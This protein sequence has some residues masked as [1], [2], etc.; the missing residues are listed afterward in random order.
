MRMIA[1]GQAWQDLG[2]DVR[3]VGQLAPLVSRIESEGFESIQI[4]A[5][6]PDPDDIHALL[7]NTYKYD[8]VAIDGYHFDAAY[9]RAVRKAGRKTLVLDDF[10][11][12]NEYEADLLLNQNPDAQGSQYNANEDISFLLGSKYALIRK[13][14][15][16][17][18]K[19]K[20]TEANRVNNVLVTM[21]DDD[22][23]NMTPKILDAIAEFV[24][25]TT[26][27]K[28]ISGAANPN[29]DELKSK[30]A[31]QPYLCDLLS[32]VNNI[33]EL[34]TWA[35]IAVTAAG[36]TCWE[37][38]YFGTPFIAIQTADNQQGIIKE[39]KKQ[40]IALCLDSKASLRDIAHEFERLF[41]KHEDRRLRSA[42][43]ISLVDGKGAIR[44]AKSMYTSALTLRPA[45][46]TDCEMLLEWRN[47]PRVRANSFK[48]D[49]IE[50][51]GHQKW[52]YEKL[53]N[54]N[55]LFYI[56]EDGSG[57]PVG[58]I[59]FDRDDSNAIISISVAPGMDGRGIGTAMTKLACCDL[60]KTWPN[61]TVV[62]L[63]KMDNP[64]SAS[65]FINA[66]FSQET[67]NNDHLRFV[68]SKTNSDAE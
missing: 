33:A 25:P 52:F 68:W 10:C 17:H 20:P 35:D 66:G 16:R 30:V 27:I 36:S 34:M 15:L 1:L 65:M 8:W 22:P 64:A 46:E 19:P 6:H 53:K 4:K 12:R 54:D 51:P 24:P 57:M 41:T 63:V 21:G 9:Q 56:A 26:H 60:W 43:G 47:D 59:R 40:E 37:L 29:F 2:G 38:C 31:N 5:I 11:N 55:C 61:I 45:H 50:L 62:A 48:S 49:L 44:V 58:Q 39:L 32:A 23:A 13:D 67:T 7:S 3:F 18:G 28:V 42:K 14:F